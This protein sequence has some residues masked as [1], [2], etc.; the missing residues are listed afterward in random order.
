MSLEHSPGR[1]RKIA[2]AAITDPSYTLEEF[3]AAERM[4]RSMLYKAWTEGWGPDFYWV[5]AT[6]RITHRA[7]LEWKRQREVEA[8]A[9]KTEK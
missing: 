5:G 9:G 3:C 1:D 7:R 8:A 2:N 4:S 6:R